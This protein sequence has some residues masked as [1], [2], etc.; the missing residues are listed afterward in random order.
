MI[1][2]AGAERSG[3]SQWTA[4][5]ILARLPWCRRV[6]IAAQEYDETHQELEYVVEGLRALGGLADSSMPKTGKW[7][8]TALGGV[9]I[10]TISLHDGP[11]ELT[12]RGRPFDVVA[13]VEAGRIRYDAF[14]RARGRV[15]EVRGTV[16]LSGTLWDTYGWYADLYKSF[17]GPNVFNGE[18]FAFPAWVN[19]AIYPGGRQ[20]PEIL[21]LERQY[22]RDEFARLVAAEVLPSPARMYPEFKYET[23][24]RAVPF[25]PDLPVELAVDPGYFPSHYAVLALQVGQE[26]VEIEGEGLV[27]ME[28][29]RQIDEVWEHHLTHR[30]VIDLCRQREWWGSVTRAVGG[31]ETKQHQAS[32]SAQEVWETIVG[33]EEDDPPRFR[34]D[35]FD[36]GK[37]LDGVVRV[38]TFLRDPASN[39]ARYRCDVECTG[40]QEEWQAY[41]R[42]TDSKGNVIS[43]EP[44]DRNNDAM[45]AFRNWIVDRYGLV[46][47]PKRQPRR[48][49]RRSRPR[50]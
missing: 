48:T 39:A 31:H 40:T 14:L 45:D 17:A 36:S 41:K 50:G 20:D 15:A 38:K 43:E 13:L 4:S 23:H 47:R 32:E 2:I 8:A 10:E 25:D 29:I 49:R 35:V 9:E 26:A 27:Q 44:E 16:I 3:K 33:Q 37:I 11:E 42:R 1:L 28:V 30:D 21:D 12:G 46:E 24:V 22:P 34:F 6:A 18:R 5:E 7:Q 19:R